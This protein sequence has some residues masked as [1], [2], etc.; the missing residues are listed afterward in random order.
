MQLSREESIA[1][2]GD[3][4]E[5]PISLKSLLEQFSGK[6]NIDQ[7]SEGISNTFAEGVLTNLEEVNQQECAVCLDLM[8]NPVLVPNCL[9]TW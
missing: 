7:A 3:D 6:S 9:H 5:S 4:G 1:P 8:E 2:E